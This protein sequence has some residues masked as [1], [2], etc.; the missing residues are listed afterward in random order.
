MGGQAVREHEPVITVGIPVYNGERYLTEALSSVLSSGYSQ[1]EIIV[2]DDG[3]T[4]ESR[5]IPNELSDARVQVLTGSENQGLAA[6]RHRIVPE[7]RGLFVASLDQDH[8]SY[9][10]RL[11]LQC[12]YLPGT[13]ASAYAAA[14]H[15][16]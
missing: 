6:A 4:D 2:R 14:R 15:A 9:P 16:S 3:A 7:A 12:A 11:G 8:L 10:D 5:K 13:R 1:L